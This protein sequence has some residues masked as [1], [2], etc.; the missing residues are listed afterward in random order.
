MN[1]R[2]TTVVPSTIKGVGQECPPHTVC[3]SH[4]SA[5]LSAGRPTG[6]AR[7]GLGTQGPSTP[8]LIPR[9]EFNCYARDDRSSDGPVWPTGGWPRLSDYPVEMSVGGRAHLLFFLTTM[10]A[11]PS[12]P[13]FGKGGITQHYPS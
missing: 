10:A 6:I 2:S 11:A 12:F 7:S 1:G 13:S 9:R 4:P 5:S 8:R 3:G